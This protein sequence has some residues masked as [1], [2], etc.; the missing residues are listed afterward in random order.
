MIKKI[1]IGVKVNTQFFYYLLNVS[2]DVIKIL[3]LL[4]PWPNIMSYGEMSLIVR[5]V[6]R[7]V[8]WLWV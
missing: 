6:W 5:S 8:H 7:A 1:Q 4:K 3:I 2:K